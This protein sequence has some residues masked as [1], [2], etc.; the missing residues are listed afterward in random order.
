[1]ASKNAAKLFD[2]VQE[3]FCCEL[4]GH[5]PGNPCSRSKIGNLSDL[6]LEILLYILLA[7]F[8]VVNLIYAVNVQELKELWRGKFHKASL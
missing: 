1:M 4:G 7:L 5:N 2:D 6:G 3:Y 8:P